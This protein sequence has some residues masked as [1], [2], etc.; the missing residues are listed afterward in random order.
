MMANPQLENGFIRIA[1]ELYVAM[2]R[3][4]LNGS[5]LRILHFII[6]QTYGYN[7]KSR[8]LSANYIANGTLIPVATVRKSLK[9]L[10]EKKIIIATYDSS[11]TPKTFR[12]NKKHDTWCLPKNGHTL[13]PKMSTQNSTDPMTIPYQS[14]Y[15]KMVTNKRQNKTIQKKERQSSGQPPTLDEILAY[16]RERGHTFDAEKF[17][18]TYEAVGWKSKGS[19]ISNW[20]ALADVWQK[21]ERS[22]SGR[23]PDLD[24]FGNRIKRHVRQTI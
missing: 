7:K 22:E 5:E 3:A 14:D 17:Y 19:K 13:Y 18:Y 21:T 2:Y 6:A 24:E 23:D 12:V 20:K 15:P 4:D 1:N 10:V 16:C 9:S 11:N 8:M